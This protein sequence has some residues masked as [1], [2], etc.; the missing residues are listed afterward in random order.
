[1]NK[2]MLMPDLGP[3][4][5]HPAAVSAA[6]KNPLCSGHKTRGGECSFSGILFCIGMK[7]LG[8]ELPPWFVVGM[9]RGETV[10]LLYSFILKYLYVFCVEQ[11]R[12]C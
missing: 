8:H 12:N 6:P 1:M 9:E 4:V 10:S 3:N 5:E 7:P 2:V 11:G